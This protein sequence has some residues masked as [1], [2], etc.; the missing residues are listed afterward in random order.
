MR[1]AASTR[2]P[3]DR[4]TITPRVIAWISAIARFGVLT[5]EQV[6]KLDGGSR[7]NVIRGL[8]ECT[9]HGLIRRADTPLDAPF[10][11]FYDAR[12]RAFCVTARGLKCL[13]AA[14][15]S[16]NVTPKRSQVLLAHEIETAEIFFILSAD[17]AARGI[18]LIDQPELL[19]LGFIPQS[20]RAMQKPLRLVG[21]A[22]PHDFP[23]LQ[24]VLKKP[25][26]IGTECDRACMP[27][28]PN[29]TSWWWCVENDRGT[30]DVTTHRVNG[31]ATW[32]KK[33]LGYYTAWKSGAHIMQWGEP[34]KALRVLTIT[35][36]EKRID[37]MI[38]VND[39]IGVPAGLM[40]FATRDRLAKHGA[41]GPAWRSA[42]ADRLSPIDR[43]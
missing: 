42:K 12:P 3:A 25:T 11:G 7:Q 27:I 36:S 38:A 28:L 31:R 32:F 43:G 17:A 9:D 13:E 39:H 29:Q 8:K 1:L 6:A 35:T 24:P 5:S 4:F 14:G 20:T 19:G 10:T 15:V 33:A 22:H 26:S 18:Q 41:L 16:L 21:K 40:L 30:E 37:S 34:A 2:T 23:H